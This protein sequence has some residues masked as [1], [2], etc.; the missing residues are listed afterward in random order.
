MNFLLKF[1]SAD[2]RQLIV[3]GQRIIASVNTTKERRA[4][5]AY[6]IEMLA[7]GKVT[8]AEWAKFGS[9]LGI[10]RGRH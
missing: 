6:G 2:T 5:V 8:V 4:A 10:L 1:L 7:D 9:R 3:L